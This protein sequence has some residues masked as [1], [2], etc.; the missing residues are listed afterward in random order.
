MVWIYGLVDPRS[1][2]LR[3]IG[4]SAFVEQRYM[5]HWNAP[6]PC[7]RLWIEDLKA[8]HLRPKLIRLEVLEQGNGVREERLWIVTERNAGTPLLNKD[9]RKR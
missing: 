5:Q 8:N 6:I 7:L 4:R 9:Y 3:Y 2:D 1:W